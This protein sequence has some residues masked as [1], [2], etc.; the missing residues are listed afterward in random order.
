MKS[1][2]EN[3]NSHFCNPEAQ[4]QDDGL[5]PPRDDAYAD[6]RDLIVGPERRQIDEIQGRLDD[7]IKRAEEISRAL[8]DAMLL[9]TARDD[10]IAKALQPAMDSALKS[11]VRKNPKALA[12]AI[13]PILG[14]GIRK[15]VSSILMGMIQSL[16]RVLDTAFSLRGIKWRFEAIRSRRP[17]A[18][19]VLLNTL[20]YQV[21][22]IFL[23]HRGTGLVLQH[24]SS[25]DIVSRDPDLVSAMLSAIQDFVNDSFPTETS[26]SLETLRMGEGLSVMIEQNRD[27]ILAAVIRGTPPVEQREKFRGMLAEIQRKYGAQIESFEGDSGPFIVLKNSLEEGL[28]H[29]L[30]TDAK[31]TSPLF[32][33]VCILVLAALGYLVHRPIHNNRLWK[34]FVQEV[35]NR[36]GIV[37]TDFGREDGRYYITGL[38]DPLVTET[39]EIQAAYPFET[40]ALTM[41]WIPYD[42]PDP[43]FI[44]KRAVKILAPPETVRLSL[45]GN[46]L[47]AIGS[48]SHEWVEF[49]WHRAETIAGVDAINMAELV[50]ADAADLDR[51]SKRLS[52]VK[53]RFPKESYTPFAGQ[54]EA[55]DL[56]GAMIEE[57]QM[58]SG[59]LGT[60]V[61]IVLFGHTDPSGTE[62]YNRRLARD[63]ADAILMLLMGKGISPAG[64]STIGIPAEIADSGHDTEKKERREKRTVTFNAYYTIKKMKAES[65]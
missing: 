26:N 13:Y 47:G 28:D 54:E 35:K 53:I 57:I 39:D 22:Q 1:L 52:D 46:C 48:A 43:A 19:I 34:G 59:R 15:A 62:F 40:P 58:L 4:E 17:F 61:R 38:K 25:L 29:R 7:P 49:F 56:A 5:T 42:S 11:S 55:L 8:P 23:I 60:P 18:E 9:G 27:A 21:E 33:V 65:R 14:P 63:R 45:S 30:R 37:I 10:R 24:V 32:W 16:N 36:P 41:N 31:R 6:L 2:P 12:D 3:P 64:L 50:D 20:V 44:L 51:A